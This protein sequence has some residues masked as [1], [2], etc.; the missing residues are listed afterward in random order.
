MKSQLSE[1]RQKA[2]HAHFIGSIKALER[3]I[4]E[5][6]RDAQDLKCLAVWA[7][8]G[9]WESVGEDKREQVVCKDSESDS[10]RWIMNERQDDMGPGGWDSLLPDVKVEKITGDHFSIMGRQ[11]VCCTI[12]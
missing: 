11:Q 1:Q 7:K 2:T 12:E 6:M 10:H 5:P 4:P 8:S 3:Y 9:V